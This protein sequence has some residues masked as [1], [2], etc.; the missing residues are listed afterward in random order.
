MSAALPRGESRVLRP[1]TS[2]ARN[3]GV[4]RMNAHRTLTTSTLGATGLALAGLLSV[5]AAVGAASP[6][7]AAA[8]CQLDVRSLKALDLNDND[9]ADEVLLRLA[10]DRTPVQTYVVTQKRFNLGT[11]VFQGSIDLDIVEKDNGQTT[12]IGS[13][14]NIQCQN[15]PLTTR[16]RSGF[17]AIY[18]VAY[19]V[20]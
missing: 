1:S 4:N 13:V 2:P 19:T 6:A 14:D 18:R 7:S 17:G 12:T 10:G 11:K 20:Q 9:G 15:R 5:G 16:D 8:T 3:E